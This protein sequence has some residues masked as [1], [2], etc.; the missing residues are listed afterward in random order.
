MACPGEA[1]LSAR[2]FEATK[3]GCVGH[4]FSW[5]S[6]ASGR[7]YAGTVPNAGAPCLRELCR[8]RAVL[9]SNVPTFGGEGYTGMTVEN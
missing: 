3:A 6:V 1:V 5:L 2:E 7:C 9:F 4:L 8:L